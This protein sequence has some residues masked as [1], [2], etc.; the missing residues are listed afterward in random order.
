M[1]NAFGRTAMIL[2]LGVFTALGGCRATTDRIRVLEA[3]KSDLERKNLE[4]RNKVAGTQSNLMEAKAK[5][6]AEE[7]RRRAAEREAELWRTRKEKTAAKPKPEPVVGVDAKGLR[8]RMP[9][10][11]DVVE[12][13]DG[14][15]AIVL[16]SDITF[17]P[18]RADLNRDAE[19][20]LARVVKALRETDGITTVRIEGH[21]DSDPIRKS[22]W[23]SNEELSLARAK[24]VE[25]YLAKHGMTDAALSVQGHGSERPIAS[26]T[27]KSGKAKNR[28]V[29]IVVLD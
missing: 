1:R 20:I 3:E 2:G 19:K 27:T 10:G 22:G 6:E 29:E 9:K 28:R 8:D 12:R 25:R 17:Q 11:V 7:A 18:G 13:A 21:T 23:K 4:L 15:T 26:N 24:S 16:A 14:D 5:A